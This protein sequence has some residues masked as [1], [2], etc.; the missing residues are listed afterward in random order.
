MHILSLFSSLVASAF[1]I[2]GLYIYSLK[3]KYKTYKIFLFLCVLMTI[4]SISYSFYFSAL[5]KENIIFW[6]KIS[7]LGW[8]F[9][10]VTVF[11]LFFELTKRKKKINEYL[12]YFII[13]LPAVFFVYRAFYNLL[14][15]SDFLLIDNLW[16]VVPASDSIYFWLYIFYFIFYSLT[17]YFMIVKW[18]K[19]TLYNKEKQ[20]AKLLIIVIGIIYL[21]TIAT[22]IVLPY[23]GIRYIPEIAHIIAL[24]IVLSV[25]YSMKKYNMMRLTPDIAANEIISSIRDFIFFI[26]K[27]GYIIN[28]N[29]YVYKTLSYS[30]DELIGKHFSNV[31]EEKDIIINNLNLI[32]NF[33]F[34]NNDL[35]IFKKN[36]EKIPVNFSFTLLKDKFNDIM[37]SIATGYDISTINQLKDEIE[38][39][40]L[41][42]D[43]LV[44]SKKK[45]EEADKLKSAFLAN[46]SHEIRTPM[47]AILGFASLLNS[48]KISDENKR[49]YANIINTSG[50]QLLNLINDIIDISKIEAGQLKIHK[51]ECSINKLFSNLKTMFEGENI[52]KGKTGLEI[53]SHT[54]L[55]NGQDIVISDPLRLQ[56]ILINLIG[57]AVKFT[58]KGYVEFGYNLTSDNTVLFYV[59]DTGIGI[60]EEEQKVVFERFR[61][62]DYS[63]NRQFGGTGLGLTISKGLVELLGGTIWLESV[64]DTGSTFYFE[65]PYNPS[66]N[67]IATEKIVSEVKNDISEID[68][69]DKAILIV[70][71]DKLSLK[72]LEEVLKFT[73]IK[74]FSCSDGKAAVKLVE[75]AIRLD[76]ILMDLQLPKMNG[77]DATMQIKLINKNLPVIAQT[78]NA[79]TE[80]LQRCYESGCNDYISKPIDKEELI[81][82]IRK[83][84]H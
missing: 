79:M 36:N 25:A 78:A 29:N 74:I 62:A 43:Q 48:D 26:D 59:T 69:S 44:I 5:I 14:F 40:M 39:R 13:Y 64:E 28:A 76:L 37:G 75:N 83:F 34:V 21:I 8:C 73:K 6:Y 41:I 55:E 70:E 45:A 52:R 60:S 56:Q 17:S 31:F 80:D 63:M 16:F 68:W 1:L 2:I 4:Y 65:L 57:N 9:M 42:Q 38:E 23:F 30:P 53:R 61:Q 32:K 58:E 51:E 24:F 77:Y 27:D 71:D 50:K 49:D 47:N 66:G 33:N 84:L 15:A 19:T 35:N 72:Y 18:Y 20:Q 7:S 11:H 46:M 54:S 22:N 82:K 67:I 81:H 12:F 10:P 3:P